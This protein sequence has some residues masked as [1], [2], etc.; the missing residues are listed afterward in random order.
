MLEHSEG[1][2]Y[3]AR[4]SE[5]LRTEHALAVLDA[6]GLSRSILVGHSEGGFIASRLPSPIPRVEK[7]VIV[8]SGSTAPQFGDERDLPILAASAQAYDWEHEASSEEAFVEAFGRGGT[9]AEPD[10]AGREGCHALPPGVG[11]RPPSRGRHAK[12]MAANASSRC[13][14]W[15]ATAIAI[16]PGRTGS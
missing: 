12:H 13:W 9:K 6:L 8:A 11:R 10:G 1:A 7:L 5:M 2:G 16:A 3:A 15:A 4:N 14:S